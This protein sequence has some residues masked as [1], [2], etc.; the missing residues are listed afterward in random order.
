MNQRGF[1]ALPKLSPLGWVL[2]VMGILCAVL[3]GWA[4]LERSGRMSCKAE[5]VTA[6]AQIAVLSDTIV[7]QNAGIQAAAD[8]GAA[9]QESVGKMLEAARKLTAAGTRLGDSIGHAKGVLG[10][11]APKGADCG[12][13]W[14]EIE[15][16][17]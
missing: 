12:T 5:L 14:R 3:T 6:R 2:V 8:A 9:A 1:V 17:K 15:G 10:K 16:T 13:A 7:R 4:L 11:P